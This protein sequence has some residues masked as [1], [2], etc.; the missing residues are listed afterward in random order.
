M[1]HRSVRSGLLLLGALWALG[2]W[3][4]GV[5]DVERHRECSYC[6]MDRKAYGFSRV[7][8]VYADGSEVGVC[9]LHC[10]VIELGEHPG[11]GLRVLRVADR[12]TH[13]LLDAE[14]ATWV[15]GGRKRPVM[16]ARPKWA[17]ATRAR[18]EAFV[19]TQGGGIVAWDE[20]LAAAREDVEEER[21]ALAARRAAA[22][23]GC[24]AAAR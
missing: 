15:M 1:R 2:V 10:A 7:L 6:G 8:V 24:A 18:A 19:A 20:V 9:S 5:E 4:G 16:A 17:F 3:A 13:E 21:R 12:D 22:P 14:A 23:F 11:K